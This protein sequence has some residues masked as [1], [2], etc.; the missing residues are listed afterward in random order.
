MFI[1]KSQ[2]FVYLRV[3][4]TGS[5]SMSNYLIDKVG[6]KEDSIYTLINLLN[7]PGVNLPLGLEG[8]NPHSTVSQIV[9]AGIVDATFIEQTN[10]YACLRNPVDRFVSRC[11]H[12]KH[13]EKHPVAQTM[14]KNELVGYAFSQINPSWHMWWPQTTWCLRNGKPVNKLFLYEDFDKAAAEMTGVAGAV[15]YYHRND[16]WEHNDI[17]PLDTNLVQEI[18]KLYAADV[19]LYKSI[20]AG[21]T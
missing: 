1:S 9:D 10:I 17:A 6:K 4:K 15:N 20:K 18:E 2:N 12:I 14:N 7:L 21:A 19:A 8:F 5:T 13:F 3:P 16:C 11:Y